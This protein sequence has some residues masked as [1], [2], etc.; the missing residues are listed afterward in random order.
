[1]KT[2]KII[3]GL[4]ALLGFTSCNLYDPPVMYGMPHADYDVKC[5]VTDADE[6]P[7]EGIKVSAIWHD[8]QYAVAL[9][10]TDEPAYTDALNI[11]RT[12]ADG[13]YLF[14][15][16]SR[17]GWGRGTLEVTVED[18][19]GEANGGDFATQTTETEFT[20][21]DFVGGDSSWYV[22]KVTKTIDFTLEPKPAP[23][24]TP[25]PTPDPENP[26]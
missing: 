5:R 23:D 10:P 9:D 20:S 18:T 25:T 8:Y 7:I 4:L 16:M 22:G 2:T 12:N 14:L 1:M 17:I 13:E 24:P 3:T 11:G 15:D 6:K 26:E 21:S 19:D